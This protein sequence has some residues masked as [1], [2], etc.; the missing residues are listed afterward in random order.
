MLS[1]NLG[2]EIPY[3]L[4]SWPVLIIALGFIA[5]IK[6]QFRKP[7]AYIMVLIGS[8]FLLKEMVPGYQVHEI[9]FPLAITSL[10]I[11]V[12][13]KRNDHPFAQK[14]KDWHDYKHCK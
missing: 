13:L 11:F 2:M 6:H 5:G 8:V 9:A 14:S 1:R 12:I 3:W 4:T 7:G 10:G